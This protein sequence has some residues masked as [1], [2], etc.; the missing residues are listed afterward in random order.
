MASTQCGDTTLGNG[1]TE[2]FS[3]LMTCS[4]CG[5]R[6]LFHLVECD[7]IKIPENCYMSPFMPTNLV[8][9]I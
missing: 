8:N 6:H 3:E 4:N 5:C 9:V 1:K 7:R 2:L